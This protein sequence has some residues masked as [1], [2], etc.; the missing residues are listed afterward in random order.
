MGVE[1]VGVDHREFCEGG[2]PAG[3]GLVF[4]EF[5]GCGARL[6]R[7]T[8]SLFGVFAGSLVLDVHDR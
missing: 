8:A 3:D 2:F 7:G 4:D 5:A 6:A 1:T